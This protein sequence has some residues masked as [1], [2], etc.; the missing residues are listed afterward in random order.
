MEIDRNPPDIWIDPQALRRVF[1]NL[2]ENAISAM[3]GEGR[4]RIAV[5]HDFGRSTLR[6]QVED[7]G[8]GIPPE[9][10]DRI[11][12]PYFSTRDA[13]MGLGLAIVQRI[14]SEHRGPI[15]HAPASPSGAVFTIE[16]PVPEPAPPAERAAHRRET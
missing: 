12:L 2:F 7:S 8:P 4:I 3:K 15:T 5:T 11:F 9:A 10:V 16:L 14:V 1:S 13:G 6:I